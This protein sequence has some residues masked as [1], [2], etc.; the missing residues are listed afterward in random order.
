MKT[1][2]LFYRGTIQCKPNKPDLG[3]SLV[4][5]LVSL[6]II[7]ITLGVMGP[8]FFSQRE[9][10]YN[11]QRKLLASSVAQ[12]YLEDYR[13][14]IRST[15]PYLNESITS[16]VTRN[17]DNST[18]P[19]TMSF[20]VDIRVRDVNGVAANNSPNCVATAVTDSPARCIRVR[21]RAVNNNINNP[22]LYE[23]EAVYAKIQ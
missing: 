16:V 20:G 4:E 14:Q 23:I 5:A 15:L 3:F 8:L 22:L 2:L 7:T 19:N 13:S 21:I 12:Y 11:N 10:N 1:L 6:I 9:G 18:T 17:L